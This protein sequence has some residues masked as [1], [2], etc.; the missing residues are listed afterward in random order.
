MPACIG[1]FKQEGKEGG[2]SSSGGPGP[3][4]EQTDGRGRG[5]PEA[6]QAVAV[7]WACALPDMADRCVWAV[8]DM[9]VHAGNYFWTH[10]FYRLLGAAYTFPAHQLNQARPCCAYARLPAGDLCIA[11]WAPAHR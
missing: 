3:W 6:P 2:D 8:V 7:C 9:A 11:G 5:A 4:Q 1:M 10:Y